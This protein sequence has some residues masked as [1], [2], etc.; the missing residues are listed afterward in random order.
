MRE[1]FRPDDRLALV[2]HEL[3]HPGPLPR[4]ENEPGGE[5][6]I[7]RPIVEVTLRAEPHPPQDPLLQIFGRRFATQFFLQDLMENLERARPVDESLPRF[8]HHREAERGRVAIAVIVYLQAEARRQPAGEIEQ[9]PNRHLRFARIFA[10]G[11]DRVRDVF[12]ETEDTVLRGREPSQIPEGFCPAVNSLRRVGGS[13]SGII[14]EQ[15]L[16]I[17]DGEK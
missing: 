16:P 17:L 12:V 8:R 13:A 15:R 14:L 4:R 1:R 5:E 10:P 3:T 7:A 9:L 2:E 6:R 11:S